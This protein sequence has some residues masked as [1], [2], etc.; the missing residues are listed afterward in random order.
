VACAPPPDPSAIDQ[1]DLLDALEDRGRL[2]RWPDP[3]YREELF[4]S[5]DRAALGADPF[6]N[7]DRGAYLR[8]E[9]VD[10]RTEHVLLDEDGPGAIVRMWS[11]N[12][13]R[14]GMLR[15]SIDGRPALVRPAADGFAGG[16]TGAFGGRFGAAWS[17]SL[18]IPFA[19]HARVTI[20]Q[21]PGRG[22][23]WQIE[24]I[25]WPAGMKVASWTG[26]ADT[27]SDLAGRARRWLAPPS[28]DAIARTPV[29]LAAGESAAVDLPP[30]PFA[31]ESLEWEGDPGE[32]AVELWFD[33]ERTADVPL[34]AL[35]GRPIGHLAGSSAM[36]DVDD[37]RMAARYVMPWRAEARVVLRGP[38]EGTLV[39][40]GRPWAWDER[41]LHFHAA[42]VG[43][44]RPT[45][46]LS[47]LRLAAL[48]GRGVYLGETWWVDNASDR[49]WGEG[50]EIGR[51]DGEI[52]HRG[53]GTE[54]WHGYAYCA[55]QPFVAPLF[56]LS[57][58][59]AAEEQGDACEHSR[60][61]AASTRARLL[62]AIPFLTSYDLDLE[63]WHKDADAT[64][65][66]DVVT[67]WYQ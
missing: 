39:A 37:R 38:A 65:G 24:A 52:T 45:R 50:D 29:H 55:N 18:P 40:R 35:L 13:D 56:D 47:L 53:T 41:S 1:A 30:G 57:W 62:D 27:P 16:V 4:S 11:A 28:G 58:A 43:D 19:R 61:R 10:G 64:L 20:D 9:V 46:P 42:R 32:A 3:P 21:S 59:D 63:L 25:R 6:A 5:W 17:T 60:G 23:Y 54:D 2:A 49:W 8:D 14:A 15:L 66:V 36:F 67:R 22:I 26:P 34:G 44:R 12:A 7:E 48:V 31:V 33:G 51:V